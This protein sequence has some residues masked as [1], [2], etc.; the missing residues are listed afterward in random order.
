[1]SPAGPPGLVVDLASTRD[2]TCELDD[3]GALACW[4]GVRTPRPAFFAELPPLRAIAANPYALCMLTREGVLS[5]LSL[6]GWTQG[7]RA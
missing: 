3:R 1:M 7:L 5:G 4:G 2:Y 6:G